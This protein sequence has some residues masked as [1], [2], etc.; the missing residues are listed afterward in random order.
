MA[1]KR[2]AARS[3]YDVHPGVAM[4]QKWVAELPEKTGRS[5]EQWAAVVRKLK[6]ADA[7]EKRDWLRAE[8]GLGTNAAWWI[9]EYAEGVNNW[10]ADPETY[11]KAA[12][13]YVDGM[14]VKRK[15]WQRPIFDEVVSFARSLGSDVKVCPC[16]TIVPI[17]RSRVFAELK[18]ATKSRLELSLALDETPF[19]AP[20]RQNPRAKG[21]DRLRHQIAITGP[22]DFDAT[23]RKWLKAAYERDAR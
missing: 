14:F 22:T 8:C 17:Y 4:V 5:L 19:V 7:S 9:V 16:Q 11:L 12:V 2:K 10:D 13:R 1:T 6:L 23:A 20:L 21:N 18:P 3:P 15:E